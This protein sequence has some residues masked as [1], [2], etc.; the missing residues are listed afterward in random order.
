MKQCL[1]AV[2]INPLF[3][4]TEHRL[5]A[6][7]YIEISDNRPELLL[8]YKIYVPHDTRQTKCSFIAQTSIRNNDIA[9]MYIRVMC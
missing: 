5:W 7:Q 1:V 3:V 8:K 6:V 9:Y 4:H 2:L